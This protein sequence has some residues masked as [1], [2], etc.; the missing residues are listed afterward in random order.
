MET[1]TLTIC[2][3]S[4]S[5]RVMD[6]IVNRLTKQFEDQ[7]GKIDAVV[8]PS[9]IEAVL[10]CAVARHM[11]VPF[12]TT[13]HEYG[14]DQ[15]AFHRGFIPSEN[16]KCLFIDDLIFSGDSANENIAFLQNQ[17]L[18]VVGISVIGPRENIRFPIQFRSLLSI[19]FTKSN[20]EDCRLCKN[21][22]PITY[23]NIRE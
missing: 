14:T 20:A 7:K 17:R 18:N 6:E 23:T 2:N 4:V 21:F 15:L 12:T 10:V 16:S 5:P 19:E 1:D 8:E 13:Y 9:I 11:D 22:V 3:F